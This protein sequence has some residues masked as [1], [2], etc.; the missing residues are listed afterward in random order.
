MT[1]SSPATATMKKEV[2]PV[3]MQF[4]IPMY[5]VTGL[6]V[7]VCTPLN[8]RCKPKL[9]TCLVGINGMRFRV[10]HLPCDTCLYSQYP[11]VRM[12]TTSCTSTATAIEQ[13][14]AAKTRKNSSDSTTPK[15]FIRIKVVDFLLLLLLLLHW[16]LLLMLSLP[17]CLCLHL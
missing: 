6:Q 1:L 17:L 13:R 14:K 9:L 8:F 4:E 5:N 12:T 15:M 7:G 10:F 16:P 11:Q 2:G 3:S